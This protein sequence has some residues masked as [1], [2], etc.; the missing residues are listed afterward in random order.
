MSGTQPGFDPPGSPT[1]HEAVAEALASVRAEGL[2]PGPE[3][4]ERL[5]AYADGRL[6]CADAV[7]QLLQHYRR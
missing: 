4:L 2:E 6:T 5:Q 1:R 3:C 7:E